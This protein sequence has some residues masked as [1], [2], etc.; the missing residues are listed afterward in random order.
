MKSKPVSF[1]RDSVKR[2]CEELAEMGLL[3]DS[4]LRRNG[5]VVWTL[6]PRGRAWAYSPRLQESKKH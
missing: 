4:G 2:A 1:D 5:L 3:Q 6:T